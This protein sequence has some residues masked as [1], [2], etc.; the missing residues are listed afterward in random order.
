MEKPYVLELKKELGEELVVSHGSPHGAGSPYPLGR[1]GTPGGH[2]TPTPYD[3]S[4]TLH[5]SHGGHE[6]AF[7]A[8][9]LAAEP[10]LVEGTPHIVYP[11]GGGETLEPAA[12]AT[13]RPISP[14]PLPAFSCGQAEPT[15]SY[16]CLQPNGTVSPLQSYAPYV[17]YGGAASGNCSYYAPP[18]TYKH[19]RYVTQ[20]YELSSAY[21][22]VL[23][24]DI[25]RINSG[26]GSSKEHDAVS[27]MY[28]Y[29]GAPASMAAQPSLSY[30]GVTWQGAYDVTD[31]RKLDFDDPANQE[32][33]ECVNCGTIS[34]PLWRRDS[35]NH[36]LCNACGNYL[37]TNGTNRNPPK[38]SASKRLNTPATNRRL[39][40][41]CANCHTTTTTLWRRNNVGEPVCNAC[42]LYFKLHQVN[43]PMTMRK[44]GIQT[45]KRKPKNMNP[46]KGLLKSQA[47]SSMMP[48]SQLSST[49]TS[50]EFYS[51]HYPSEFAVSASSG[52]SVLPLV[53]M[54]PASSAGN[55]SR[56][57]YN[58]SELDTV[59]LSGVAGDK[60]EKPQV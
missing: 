30:N 29:T 38:G 10:V 52:G 58:T 9:A 41:S 33:R 24:V 8:E 27:W 32:G 59:S 57:L 14:P 2:A 49:Y 23:P 18:P 1:N 60:L 48:V 15:L 13:L 11:G 26:G 45:R 21:A 55:H 19:E 37:K 43:R 53:T 17:S 22:P 20:G 5:A 3:D 35:T 7:K 16:T 39:G 56:I 50:N 4:V 31:L 47:R 54:P 42:G 46:E 34:T 6:I 40:L 12:M 25:Q 51:Q 44:D 28:D 36:F